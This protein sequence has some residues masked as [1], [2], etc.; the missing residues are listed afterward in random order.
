MV[1]ISKKNS[2]P[3]D[4]STYRGITLESCLLKLLTTV[5]SAQMEEWITIA[6]LLLHNQVDFRPYYQ[7]EVNIF[8]LNHILDEAKE[9]GRD[10]YIAFVDLTK[11]FDTVSRPLLW[12]KRELPNDR[13]V[14]NNCHSCS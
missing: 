6:K 4:P 5:I 9:L 11:A 10:V 1:P 13:T 8:T 12:N 3:D 7:T 14:Q 2:K